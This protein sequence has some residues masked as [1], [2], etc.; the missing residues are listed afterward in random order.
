MNQG[1]IR[2]TPI[3]LRLWFYIIQ[4]LKIA[5]KF[6]INGQFWNKLFLIVIFSSSLVKAA[7]N[8]PHICKWR[9]GVY[10]RPQFIIFQVPKTQQ[11]TLRTC[12]LRRDR[13]YEA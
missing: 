1:K 5:K 4:G 2:H 8:A 11:R 7:M 13:V 9:N 6:Y 10:K 12:Q 3:R